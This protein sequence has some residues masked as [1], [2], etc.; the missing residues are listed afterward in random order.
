M[1]YCVT[2]RCR[3]PENPDSDR[4]CMSCGAKLWLQDRY[5]PIQSI[6]KGGFGRT[7]LAVDEESLSKSRCVIKQLYLENPSPD[8]FQKAKELFLQEAVRLG[9]LGTHPKIPTLLA[10]F[11]QNQ[12]LYLIQEW[13]SGKTL[14][15][16]LT[17]NGVY[18]ET[19]IWE[20]L[21]DLLPILKYIHAHNV[22]HR[23]IKPA[24]IIRRNEDNQ[25]VL[26]D[27][28]IAKLITDTAL[29]HTGTMVGTPEYMAPEQIKG[30]AVWASD[31]Y[32]LGV[33][34][35]HLLTQVPPWDMYDSINDGWVWRDFLLPERKVSDRLGRILD[36]LLQN[37]IKNRFQSVDEILQSV[38]STLPPTKLLLKNSTQ[39]THSL[40][41]SPTSTHPVIQKITS[42]NL[43]SEVG[44]DYTKLHYLLNKK[45]WKEADKE[46]WDILCQL[47]GRPS[48]YYLKLND[49]KTLPCQDLATLDQLWIKSSGGRFG[50]SIQSRIYQEV[51]EDYPSFCDRV[52]WPVYNPHVMDSAF[53]FNLKSPIGHLPSRRW[54]GGYFD[55]WRHIEI[56]T[57]KLKECGIF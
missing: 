54:V 43:V 17:Q 27:F 38:N 47:F 1:T 31:L 5:R 35:I 18:N 28:G 26:I 57:I 15:E 19:Q 16:E 33:T 2:P 32:S 48:G 24:N 8:V 7:F 9:E 21:K 23:D 42:N 53:N 36:K 34:C 22:I 20:L 30:K 49:I 29:L 37:S 13:I 11:E 45:K 46:T 6:G 56:L 25:L 10:H 12:Q 14:A 52:G 50:F 3:V 4:F 39:S 40:S 55:W 51:S 41:L 44:V